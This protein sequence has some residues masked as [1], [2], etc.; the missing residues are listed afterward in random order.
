[1]GDRFFTANFNKCSEDL[2]EFF[3]FAFYVNGNAFKV[4][5]V[6][7]AGEKLNSIFEGKN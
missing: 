3:D 6:V 7:F 2:N 1:M 5:R 4:H